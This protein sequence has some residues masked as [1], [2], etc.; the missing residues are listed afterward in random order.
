VLVLVFVSLVQFSVTV[1]AGLCCSLVVSE[2]E[3]DVQIFAYIMSTVSSL[4][5]TLNSQSIRS[6]ETQQQL[7]SFCRTHK[8]PST[9][10]RKIGAYYDYVLPRTLHSEDLELVSGLSDALRQQV[11]H[12]RSYLTV[13]F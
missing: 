10:V 12:S 2:Y 4:L 3:H 11:H 9:L 6:Q 8:L 5:S 13:H 1:L 7:D